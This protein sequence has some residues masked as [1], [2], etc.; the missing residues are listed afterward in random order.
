MKSDKITL[1]PGNIWLL[2][3]KDGTTAHYLVMK[4]MSPFV[5][6]VFEME[7][8]LIENWPFYFDRNDNHWS[9]LA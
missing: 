6:S 2:E 7:T 5:V 9:L 1:E 3:T 4:R 8:G